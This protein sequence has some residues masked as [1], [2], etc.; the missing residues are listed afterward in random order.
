MKKLLSEFFDIVEKQSNDTDRINLILN[1][2]K[3]DNFLKWMLR[4]NFDRNNI[5][6]L[7]PEGTP[8]YKKIEDR[9][10]GYEEVTLYKSQRK[11]YIWLDP[12][13]NLTKM[14][15]ESLFIELLESLHYTE[16]ELFCLIK[17]GKLTEKYPSITEG[18]VRKIFPK[19][20]PPATEPQPTVKR[21]RGRPRKEK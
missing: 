4:I 7:L 3:N 1:E 9:P 2:S 16:A 8:P 13:Q 11:F 5:K 12:R 21:G 15:R 19:L 10:M 6:M 18:L 20:L 17:D 14:K